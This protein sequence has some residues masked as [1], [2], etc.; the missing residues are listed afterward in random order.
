M[1]RIGYVIFWIG[2]LLNTVFYGG[3]FWAGFEA[4]LFDSAL[5][6]DA[7]LATLR[8][9]LLLTTDEGGVVSAV[10]TNPS[11]RE[12]RRIVYARVTE[13][14]ITLMRE[15]RV[16]LTLAPGDAQRVEWQV[17]GR[18]AAWK[19]FVLVRVYAQRSSPL[20]SRTNTCGIMVFPVSGLRGAHIVVAWVIAGLVCLGVGSKLWLV[21]LSEHNRWRYVTLAGFAVLGV[22]LGLFRFWAVAGFVLV[23]SILL[24]VIILA[25]DVVEKD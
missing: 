18:D 3:V 7:R 1:R 13:R 22:V 14:Y 16:P 19:R 25:M 24:C 15:E 20:P 12:V 9:P 11:E 17:A 5:V 2:I 8:C 23:L 10:F 4:S 6:A 21:M